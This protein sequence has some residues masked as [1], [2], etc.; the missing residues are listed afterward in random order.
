MEKFITYRGKTFQVKGT[1]ISQQLHQSLYSGLEKNQQ[2]LVDARK[3]PIKEFGSSQRK[4][5]RI[6]YLKG[7]IKE[8]RLLTTANTIN[9]KRLI[10]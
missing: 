3:A 4:K 7:Q 1:G 8:S 10:K 5:L 9:K 2:A 6:D